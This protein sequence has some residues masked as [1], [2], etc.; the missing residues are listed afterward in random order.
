M[1][2]GKRLG[3]AIKSAVRKKIDSGA[4][5]SKVEVARIFGV[6]PPSLHGWEQNGTVGKQHLPML[7]SYFSDVVPPDHWGLTSEKMEVFPTEERTSTIACI[8]LI[9]DFGLG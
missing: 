2:T 1:Y 7:F 3:E 6:T 5:K 4:V 8:M 9:F